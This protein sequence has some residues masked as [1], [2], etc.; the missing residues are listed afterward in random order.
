MTIGIHGT[1]EGHSDDPFWA[2]P[3]S[4]LDAPILQGPLSRDRREDL[5]TLA[6]ALAVSVVD[7]PGHPIEIARG[8]DPPDRTFTVNGA[9]LAVELTELTASE[10]RADLAQARQLGRLLETEL[11]GDVGRFRPLVGRRIAL[12]VL[13]MNV[14]PYDAVQMIHQ[15]CTML[16]SDRGCVGD[17]VDLSAGLPD[18][19]PNQH[20]FYGQ[21]GP[22]MVQSYRDG[23]PN[24]IVVSS[25]C[26]AQISLSQTIATV[27]E[28][29]Q[30]KDR[31]CNELLVMSC[32]MPDERGY[33]CPIDAFMFQ[34]IKEHLDRIQLS[35][36]R[37]KGVVLHLWGTPEWIDLF[38]SRDVPLVWPPRRNTS[39]P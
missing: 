12:S 26:Q 11:R 39:E 27:A 4:P 29:V 31:E 6:F 1:E 37:L 36:V 34:F 28:R 16:E 23:M 35:P 9:T 14:A 2:T 21:Q 19:W 32:G 20:G 10:I 33:V 30:V 7:N 3:A 15:L 18:P 38:R 25:S 13:P 22:V 24:E 17:G 8:A 5:Q